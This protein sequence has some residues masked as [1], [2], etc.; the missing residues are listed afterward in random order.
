[1]LRK[2]LKNDSMEHILPLGMEQELMDLKIQLPEM[3]FHTFLYQKSLGN[4]ANPHLPGIYDW[5]E[6]QW[7]QIIMRIVIEL[8]EITVNLWIKPPVI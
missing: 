8:L 3:Y 6:M 2:S 7:F 5:I 4:M 1:M